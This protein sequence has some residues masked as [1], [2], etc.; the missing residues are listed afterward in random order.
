MLSPFAFGTIIGA[1]LLWTARQLA[2]RSLLDDAMDL[3]DDFS[4]TLSLTDWLFSPVSMIG[5]TLVL[6][7][8]V[9]SSLIWRR[10]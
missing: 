5:L 6:L 9:A 8:I 1:A 4:P 7:S 2:E 3:T 10:N